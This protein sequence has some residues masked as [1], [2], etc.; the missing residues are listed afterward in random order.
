MRH[1][2]LERRA[3]IEGWIA[4][5]RSKAFMCLELRC[6]PITLDGYLRKMSLHY[7][8]NRGGKGKTAPNR[9]H[10]SVFLHEGSTI[11]SYQLKL[12]LLRDKLKDA[13]CE[14]CHRN[15]WLD[16]PMP[17]ELH[18]VNGNPFDN[19]LVNL[20][21]LCPNCHALTDNH[22]GRGMRRIVKTA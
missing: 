8:G 16:E 18:H 17:L 12:K 1:D 3:E 11:K 5:Q 15:E 2:I 9:K 19:R 10:A 7:A 6:K 20:Q 14:R 22:A 21:I 13:C 4:E